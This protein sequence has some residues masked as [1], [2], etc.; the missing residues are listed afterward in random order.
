M[1]EP[2]C[3]HAVS[4]PFATCSDNRISNTSAVYGRQC[5]RGTATVVAS[6]TPPAGGKRSITV[7]HRVPGKSVLHLMISLCPACHNKVHRTKAVLS[8][9]PPL[10][11][12]LWREQ[13]PHGH[14]QTALNFN[15]QQARAEVV[16]LFV[17]KQTIRNN[18]VCNDKTTDR[19]HP[20]ST[21]RIA[22]K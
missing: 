10:L 7:H 3:G 9:M 19:L 2:R 16:P 4:A 12:Q 22:T 18:S 15:V 8:A 1:V 17:E 11:S 14:E 6:A 20:P 21:R 13:H 5:W